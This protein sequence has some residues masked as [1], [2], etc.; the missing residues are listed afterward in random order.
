MNPLIPSVSTM[1]QADAVNLPSLLA[2]RK[3]LERFRLLVENSQDLVAEVSREG[4]I[5]Y[6]SPHVR[7]VLGYAPRDLNGTRVF[8]HIHPDDSAMVR[9]KFAS[10]EG[11]ATPRFRHQ[12]GSWRW[13]ETSGRDFFSAEGDMHRVLI[14]RDV[15]KRKESEEELKRAQR[16]NSA[17]EEQLRQTQKLESLGTL[18]GGIAHDFN[19]ILG[20]I[21][22]Y[23]ELARMDTEGRTDVHRHLQQVL[24]ACNRAK[25]LVQQILAFSR[26]Q[27]KQRIPVRLQPIVEEVFELLRSTLPKTLEMKA[28]ISSDTCLVLAD[29]TQIHQVLVNLCTNAAHAMRGRFGK[30]EVRLEPFVVDE[31]F[32]STLPELQPGPHVL[33]SVSDTGHGMDSDTIKRIF[34][35][36]FTTKGLGEG[37][38]LGL[39]VV[40]G[41][42]S[43]HEG[44]IQVVSRPG[45]GSTFH[46]YLPMENNDERTTDV[47]PASWPSGREQ[48][49]LLVDDEPALCSALE[50]LLQRMNYAVTSL[51][52]PTEAINTFLAHPDRFDLVITDMEMPGM[53]GLDLAKELLKLRPALPV[54]LTT[55]WYDTETRECVRRLGIRDLLMKPIGPGALG[56]MLDHVLNQQASTPPIPRDQRQSLSPK[57]T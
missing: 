9:E 40:H 19:N 11:S 27:K 13:L 51:K 5:L 55:G 44:A 3:N 52:S 34:E 28:A 48:H 18:A 2:L 4:V 16:A 37:T 8:E 7:A 15:T 56:E 20:A 38:G 54:L 50:G 17:L 30:L 29:P 47:P 10:L 14:A 12:D 35:P 36:F 45:H 43:D 6:V 41:I 57:L 32:A 24:K 39:A 42:V 1:L 46:V 26:Q 23:T 21:M 53:T 25:D 31:A 33:L 49:V 22:A